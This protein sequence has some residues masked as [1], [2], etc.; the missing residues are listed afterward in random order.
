MGEP[1][2]KVG[3]VSHVGISVKDCEKT[4][5]F[6]GRVFGLGPFDIQEYDMEN[7]AD[8]YLVDGKPS[9]PK[10][11]A[12]LY[13]DGDFFLEILEVQEGETVHT[14][15]MKRKGEGLQH[16]CFLVEDTKTALEKLKAE[17][18]EPVIDYQM[19]TNQRG[20]KIRIH[21]VYLNTEDMIGGM[22]IQL[23]EYIPE[24]T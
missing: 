11:K 14:R 6:L 19:V 2:I 23:L 9:W 3:R 5:E 24:P 20:K 13:Y 21:E 7:L 18:I 15:F 17:G 8:Y 1:V 4:A 16:L 10:F 22:T 12:A